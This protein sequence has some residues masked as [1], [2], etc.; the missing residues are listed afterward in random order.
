MQKGT[1]RTEA[2]KAL[3]SAGSKLR[4]PTYKAKI[5]AAHKGK[6][7]TPEQRAKMSATHRALWT[8]RRAAKEQR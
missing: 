6:P 8:A 4:D 5:S 7:K 2:S 1:H 3:I